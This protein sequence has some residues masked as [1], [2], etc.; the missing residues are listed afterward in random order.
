MNEKSELTITAR[1]DDQASEGI[2]RLAA[3]INALADAG[4]IITGAEASMAQAADNAEAFRERYVAAM[5]GL[6]WDVE[7]AFARL[8]KNGYMALARATATMVAGQKDAAKAFGKAMLEI[9]AQAILAIGQQAA[10][11]AVFALAEGLLFKDPSAI[12]AAKL[13][14]AVA[15]MALAVGGTML[16]EAEKISLGGDGGAGGRNA[17]GSASSRQGSAQEQ[18]QPGIVVNVN[19]EGH[20]VDTKAFVYEYVAPALAEAVGKGASLAGKYNLV[21]R[22]D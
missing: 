22:K 3:D 4:K 2:K 16:G 6:A 21:V 13:Y 17:G 11:K 15:A 12:A 8:I 20:V 5:S 14:G 9:S 7:V 1:F 10:V 18:A 19:V